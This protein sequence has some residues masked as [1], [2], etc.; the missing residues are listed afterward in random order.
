VQIIDAQ[1]HAYERNHPGRPWVGPLHGPPSA[2]G[3]EMVAAMDTT[4]VDGALLLSIDAR[5]Q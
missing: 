1:V 2:T 5:A 3:D 4:G